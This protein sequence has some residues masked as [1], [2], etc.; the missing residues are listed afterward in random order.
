M[1]NRALHKTMDSECE[2]TAQHYADLARQPGWWHY[3]RQQVRELEADD[4]GAFNGL[5]AA[6]ARWAISGLA[7]KKR[8]GSG[9]DD[10]EESCW[11]TTHWI[12]G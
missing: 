3:T 7:R 1:R 10:I 2:S 8:I 11:H 6:R 12:E 5:Y 4:S 9:V